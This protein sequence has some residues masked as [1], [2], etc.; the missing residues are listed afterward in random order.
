[1]VY[2]VSWTPK[3]LESYI[4]NIGYLETDWTER[5]VKKIHYR[6]RKED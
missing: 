1:M 6:C 4:S 5:E 3:A 2:K